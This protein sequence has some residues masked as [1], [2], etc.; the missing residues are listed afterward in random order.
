MKKTRYFGLLCFPDLHGCL[1]PDDAR[2]RQG[3]RAAN[4]D[5]SRKTL[6]PLSNRWLVRAPDGKLY[7]AGGVETLLPFLGFGYTA[8]GRVHAVRPIPRESVHVTKLQL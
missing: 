5:Q 2:L 4:R 8:Y 7:G 1:C 6:N 3:G